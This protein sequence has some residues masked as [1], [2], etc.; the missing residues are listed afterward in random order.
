MG[1]MFWGRISGS[2]SLLYTTVSVSISLILFSEKIFSRVLAKSSHLTAFVLRK[3]LSDFSGGIAQ[4]F[5]L[6]KR[7]VASHKFESEGLI[8]DR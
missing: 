1:S 8:V 3:T 4:A 5:G 6:I 7:L 2:A